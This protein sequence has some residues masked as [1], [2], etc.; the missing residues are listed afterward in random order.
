M[1]TEMIMT[2][3]LNGTPWAMAVGMPLL[4]LFPSVIFVG[5]ALCLVTIAYALAINPLLTELADAIDRRAAGAYA[6]VAFALLHE[7][8]E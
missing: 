3:M 1:I 2:K 8:S 7:E 4:V 6:S 5:V